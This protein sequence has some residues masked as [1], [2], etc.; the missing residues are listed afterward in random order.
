METHY[1]LPN[2]NNYITDIQP[3]NETFDETFDE[4]FGIK[5]ELEITTTTLSSIPYIESL[6]K[7]DDLISQLANLKDKFGNYDDTL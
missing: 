5:T 2:E 1:V 4:T 7:F 3:V 6:T